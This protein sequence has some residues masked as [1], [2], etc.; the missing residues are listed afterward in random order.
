MPTTDELLTGW[1]AL[2]AGPAPEPGRF[3]SQACPPAG[4]GLLRVGLLN[5]APGRPPLRMLLLRLPHRLASK[6]RSDH[7]YQGLRVEPLASS[8]GPAAEA[9]VALIL[10]LPALRDIFGVLAADVAQAAEGQADDPTRIRAFLRRLERWETLLQAFRP[11]GLSLPARQGLFGELYI[12]RRFLDDGIRPAAALTAWAGPQAAVHDFVLPGQHA[13]EVKT[14]GAGTTTARISNAAQL[15]E[16]A[17]PGR[18]WLVLVQLAAPGPAAETLPAL[19]AALAARLAASLPDAALFALRLQQAGYF[20]VQAPL[21][22]EAW[23]VGQVRVLAVRDDFPRLRAS[24]L[25]PALSN[26]TYSLDTS[27]LGS[28]EEPFASLTAAF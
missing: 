28:F 3:N 21:Y 5:P 1:L 8:A 23:A 17:P 12:L 2:E 6:Q 15:D 20:D 16:P 7:R 11:E 4:P 24:Q 19:V 13:A 9:Y 27:S 10:D 22:S 25:P 14:L 26:V 18:L